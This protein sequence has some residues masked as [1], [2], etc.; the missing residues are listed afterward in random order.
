MNAAEGV[1]ERGDLDIFGEF[2]APRERLN[3]WEWADRNV[4]FSRVPNYDTPLRGKYDSSFL[5][6]WREPAEKLTDPETREIAILKAARVGGSENVLLNA[7]RHTVACNPQPTLYVTSD[8]LSAERFMAGRIKRGL[9]A[10]EATSA[11][12]RDAQATMYDIT[13]PHMD[14][15]VTWPRQKQAFKQDGWALLLCDEVS[16]WPGYSPEMARRRVDSYPFPHIVFLS[17]PDPATKRGGDEDPIFLEYRRG[18]C[19]EWRMPDPAG[20]EFTWG[21]GSATGWGLHWDPAAKREDGTW[22]YKRVAES[23]HFVTPGGARIENAERMAFSRRGRWAPTAAATA[24]PR[25]VSYH[26]PVFLSPFGAGDFGNIA[27]SFLK[28]KADGQLRTFILEQLAEPYAEKVEQANDDELLRRCEEYGLGGDP[29][30]ALGIEEGAPKF[31]FLTVDVQ[32]EHF[33]WLARAWWPGAVGSGG[34]SALLGYGHCVEFEEL[35]AVSEQWGAAV[36]GIDCAY[37]VRNP[38]V[39]E[40][41]LQS[42]AIPLRGSDEL[43]YMPIRE[44]LVDPY[45]GRKGAGRETLAT[46]TWSVNVF[47]ALLLGMMRGESRHKWTLPKGVPLQYVVQAGSTECV[48]G[49]WQHKPGR[50]ADHLFD[51]EAMQ[52]C[53]AYLGGVYKPAAMPD[54]GHGDGAKQTGEEVEV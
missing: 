6:W 2:S 38:E 22:D 12:L 34:T 31:V 18:D 40:W 29:A 43:R 47:R 1:V 14:L 17:S 24:S 52:V 33:W 53:L 19:R 44:T 49:V 25:C 15:R 37:E 48:D 21:M 16:T 30:G 4:D 7:I 26:V 10:A 42:G 20:G 9:R 41:A 54:M 27:V 23:A 11:L 8:Q 36:V 32:A 28:A 39:F 45:R 13:F 3:V 50:R 35:E 5:P 51:C 46:Y